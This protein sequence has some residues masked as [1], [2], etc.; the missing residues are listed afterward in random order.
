M[1]ELTRISW[2]SVGSIVARVAA[3][4][5]SRSD[6]RAISGASASTRSHTAR[7]IATRWSSTTTLAAWSGRPRAGTRETTIGRIFD[8]PEREAGARL[9]HVSADAASW[10]ASV[11]ATRAPHAVLCVDP[12]HVVSWVTDALNEV[13]RVVGN[14]AWRAGNKA[15]PA[16]STGHAT[17]RG[18]TQR[19]ERAAPPRVPP[20]DRQGPG[21]PRFVAGLR[22]HRFADRLAR[23]LSHP[24]RAFGLLRRRLSSQPVDQVGT[25]LSHDCCRPVPCMEKVLVRTHGNDRRTK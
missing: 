9:T 22:R 16:S 4:A 15:L 8:R 20:A 13:R 19:T 3:E 21:S 7:A 18:R 1:A 11:V 24:S 17:P 2:R 25:L 6:P 10:I 14:K 23:G 12:S 5:R